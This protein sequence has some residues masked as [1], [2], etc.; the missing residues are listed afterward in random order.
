MIIF[1]IKEENIFVVIVYKLSVKRHI[2]DCLNINGKRRII[3]PK[4]S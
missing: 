3:M 1:Y 4:T 2:K